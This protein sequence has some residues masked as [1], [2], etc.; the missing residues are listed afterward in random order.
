MEKK[1]KFG[2]WKPTSNSHKESG[3][4][5]EGPLFIDGILNGDRYKWNCQYSTLY[6]INN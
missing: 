2:G 3:D 4:S 1:F 5:V 6:Y